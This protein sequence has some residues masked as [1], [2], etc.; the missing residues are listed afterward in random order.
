MIIPVLY[1]WSP[2]RNRAGIAK[3]GLVPRTPVGWLRDVVPMVAKL[4]GHEVIDV[5]PEQRVGVCLG[6]S[7]WH[8]WNL[9][10]AWGKP[11]EEWDLYSVVTDEGDE[12]LIRPL[13]GD[14]VEEVRVLNRIPKRRVWYVATRVV[15]P[16]ERRRM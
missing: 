3:R 5:E 13:Q 14:V 8:A 16:H 7:P 2:S 9:S 12:V 6:T 1:H 4:R 10:G 15:S 11:G